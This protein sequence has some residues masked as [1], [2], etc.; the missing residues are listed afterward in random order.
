DIFVFEVFNVFDVSATSLTFFSPA[1]A[2]GEE[3][4]AVGKVFKT[5][6]KNNTQGPVV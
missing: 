4:Q 3:S 6:Y 2:R 5:P 1:L